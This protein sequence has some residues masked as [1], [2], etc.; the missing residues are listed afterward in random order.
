MEARKSISVTVQALYDWL[1]ME[2]KNHKIIGGNMYEYHDKQ[3]RRPTRVLH[4]KQNTK[5][6]SIEYIE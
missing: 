5:Q 6:K 2:H 4:Q 3:R 1:N